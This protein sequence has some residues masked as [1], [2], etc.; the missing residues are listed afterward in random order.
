MRFLPNPGGLLEEFRVYKEVL[1]M[2]SVHCVR[3]EALQGHMFCVGVL[4][5]FSSK[6]QD[7][8]SPRTQFVFDKLSA[9]LCEM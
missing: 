9:K 4:V 1:F 7:T 2:D 3:N 6:S 5:R 8:K